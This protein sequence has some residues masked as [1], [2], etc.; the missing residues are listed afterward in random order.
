MRIVGGRWRGRRLK[1]PPD[2]RVRPTA[3]RVR[4][5]LFNILA[6]RG[7]LADAVV[8]D[9]FAGT[10]ALALEA[11]SRGAARAVLVDRDARSLALARENAAALGA[12]AQCEFVLADAAQLAPRPVGAGLAFLDA[13][14]GRGLAGPALAAAAAG[15]WLAPGAL[16]VIET[17]ADET[18]AL[19]PGVREE[20]ARLYGST[21]IVFARVEP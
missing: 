12:G 8:L 10:G 1:P 11:L 20:D 13:P 18:L 16:C 6:H 9:L 3:D 4:E 7:A 17:G 19:P 5:A 2:D 21:R 14:Y 15:G